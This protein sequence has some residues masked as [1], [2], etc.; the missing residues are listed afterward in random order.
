MLRQ[1]RSK[2]IDME[3]AYA[4]FAGALGW[5]LP[6]AAA[7]VIIVLAFKAKLGSLIDRVK[8][9]SLW[10]NKAELAETQ[11][12]QV[13]QAAAPAIL[14]PPAPGRR[15]LPPE[16][17][18]TIAPIEQDMRERLQTGSP[19]DIEAQLAWA[20]RVAASAIMDRDMEVIYRVI[21][22][23]QIAAIK[24][25]NLRGG[26]ITVKRAEEIFEQAK[27]RFPALHESRPLDQWAE[28]IFQRGLAT[29]PEEPVGPDSLSHLTDLGKQ[30]LL[31]LTA[32]GLSEDRYG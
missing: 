22:G 31:F 11:Q 29:R 2:E 13:E 3:A 14:P 19:G 9:F 18:S 21:F 26:A 4:A 16:P 23:S 28:F 25:A 30:F 32:K 5:A 7:A 1:V 8:G 17:I 10:G 20:I 12:Q 6:F 15:E 27:A 24:E